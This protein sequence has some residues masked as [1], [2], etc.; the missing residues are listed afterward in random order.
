MTAEKNIPFVRI[1]V[2]P[3]GPLGDLPDGVSWDG[4]TVSMAGDEPCHLFVVGSGDAHALRQGD[5]DGDAWREG[6]GDGNAVRYGRGRGNALRTG[7]GY[8]LALRDGGGYGS[9]VRTGDGAGDAWR[10][11]GGAGTSLRTSDVTAQYTVSD[12]FEMLNGPQAGDAEP[13]VSDEPDESDELVEQTWRFETPGPH[14]DFAIYPTT[15]GH[16]TIGVG[17][18]AVTLLPGEGANLIEILQSIGAQRV[19]QRP[20]PAA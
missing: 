8:G 12:Y 1:E 3:H 6:A 20:P 2:G 7:S 13:A 15:Y 17:P 14:I 4:T 5:G 16:G 19:P 18:M 10:D 11:G 9:A